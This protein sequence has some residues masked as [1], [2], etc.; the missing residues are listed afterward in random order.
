MKMKKIM[1][2]LVALAFAA[3]FL[4]G[5]SLILRPVAE[6]N[7]GKDK[8]QVMELLLPGSKEFTREIYEGEDRNI[9]AVYKAETGYVMEL[10]VAG[11]VDEIVIMAGVD[12]NGSVTG[13]TILDM[14]ETYGLGKRAMTDL[15]FLGQFIGTKG[16]A[17]IG[18]NVDALTGATVTSKAVTKAVNSA[19][20]YVTG[21]DVSSSATEWGD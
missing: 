15:S 18:T 9:T 17:E 4:L 6:A 12:H 20:A 8:Q 19:A 13:V 2:P 21:A 14:A 5:A 16:E 3:V 11:Y 7:E 10:T 1:V